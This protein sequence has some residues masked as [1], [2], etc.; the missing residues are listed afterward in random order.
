MSNSDM[1]RPRPTSTNGT[2]ERTEERPAGRSEAGQDPTTPLD[3]GSTGQGSPGSAWDAEGDWRPDASQ[4]TG[5][6]GSSWGTATPTSWG[7]GG[8]GG[9]WSGAGP[10][11][12]PSAPAPGA[13][14]PAPGFPA[15]TMT[16]PQR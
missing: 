6:R 15:G 14:G 2:N 5:Q 4:W 16:D 13:P 12:G 7:Q 10:G 11:G 8:A 9:G 3:A 1:W